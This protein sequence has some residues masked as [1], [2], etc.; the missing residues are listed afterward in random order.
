M[1]AAGCLP[2]LHVLQKYARAND[3]FPLPARIIDR[4]FDDLD[5]PLGLPVGIARACR[6]AAR[7]NRCSAGD[8]N[9]V[10]DAHCTRKADRWLESR[11]GRNKFAIHHITFLTRPQVLSADQ[12]PRSSRN[13]SIGADELIELIR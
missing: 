8:R 7:R 10:T 1:G 12:M 11:A 9:V 13:R 2:I 3:M 4:F 5:A 6:A